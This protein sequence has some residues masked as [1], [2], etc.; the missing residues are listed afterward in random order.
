MG[1]PGGRNKGGTKGNLENQPANR[2]VPCSPVWKAYWLLEGSAP[3]K[4]QAAREPRSSEM[5]PLRPWMLRSMN[6]AWADP[7][8]RNPR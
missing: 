4:D 1:S 6:Q 7:M 5:T 8:R 3:G 2:T